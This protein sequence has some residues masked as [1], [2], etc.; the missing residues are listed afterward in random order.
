MGD[1]DNLAKV[2]LDSLQGLLF[3][4]DRQIDHLSLLRVQTQDVEEYIVVSIRASSI[5]QHVDVLFHR[6]QH[7]WAGAEELRLADFME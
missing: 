1:L 5:N 3:S 6:L 7:G 4:N 2:L